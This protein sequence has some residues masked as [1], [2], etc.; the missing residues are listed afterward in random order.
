MSWSEC[1][2]IAL[3][4]S[5][6]TDQVSFLVISVA[7]GVGCVRLFHG[8]SVKRSRVP[9]STLSGTKNYFGQTPPAGQSPTAV[10]KVVGS[11]STTRI[12]PPKPGSASS[13]LIKTNRFVSPEPW[14][15][16]SFES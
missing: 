9:I 7:C 11:V 4:H 6:A 14:I 10:A 12:S 16:I 5:T 15:L 13:T 1:N 8:N 3:S 2:Q